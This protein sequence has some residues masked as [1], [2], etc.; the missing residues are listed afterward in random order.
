MKFDPVAIEAETRWLLAHPDF[1]EKPA[2]IKEFLGEDYLNIEALI[3]PGILQALM[4]IFG[5]EVNSD[6][7]AHYE[8]AMVTGAIGIGK[9]TVASIALPYMAHWVLC[10]KNPQAYFNLLPGSRIAFMQMST[11]EKQASEVVFGDIFARIQHSKWFVEN[12]PYDDKFTKQIRF[13]KDIWILPGDSSET[14]FEGYNIL[15]GILDEMDSHKITQERDYADLG[16]DTIRGR[17]LSRFVVMGED[18]AE[19]GH[20]GLLICIGQMKKANGFAARKYKEFLKRPKTAYVVRMT[21]WDSLG[22]EKFSNKSGERLSFWYDIKRKQIIPAIA[23]SILKSESVIEIPLAFKTNFENAPE[24]SLRDLA[25]IPPATSDPF[26]SLVDRIEECRERWIERHGDESPVD[27]SP[28]R[29]KFADWFISRDPRKRH[30]HIDLAY[31]A[32][33]DAL[34]MAMGYVESVVEIEGEKKPYI[35]FDMLLRM[36]ASPGTEIMI[37]DVRRI[38]YDLKLDKHF[39]VYS[40]SMDGFQSTDTMQQL[41]KRKFVVDY[42]SIDKSTLP[43]ED[44]REAIYERRVEFPP[45]VTYLQKG[46]TERV[47]IAVKELMELTE[48]GKKVDHPPEGSKDVA[49]AMAGV[50]STLMGD[51]TYRRGVSSLPASSDVLADT[52]LPT[53]STGEGGIVIPMTGRGLGLKA[54]VPPSSDVYT[55]LTIPPRLRP[56]ER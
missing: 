49:D 27:D 50:T 52:L 40:V 44:L 35:V 36:H 34:G 23:A 8:D 32:N 53:G 20:R 18:G 10:L 31:S 26:I 19:M 3:R 16:Y 7:I 4:D 11:S 5:E 47:E 51:R 42:L 30:I 17:I 14:T 43:Y 55:G 56:R 39:K 9:T 13:P 41:R 29:P 54:P 38:I 2:S 6:R 46:D 48:D 22:W 21:L 12:Y 33:G 28:T 45:Y 15:G 24:K 25:G 37:S 1:D